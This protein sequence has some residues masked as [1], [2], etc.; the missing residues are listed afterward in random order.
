MH[1]VFQ[2]LLSVKW[3]LFAKWGSSLMLLL[4]L[5]YTLIWT[6]LGIFIPRDRKYY[7]PISSNWWRLVLELIGVILTGYFIFMVSNLC[8]CC[9]LVWR[10]LC[11]TH[12][13][14]ISDENIGTNV[15]NRS[16]ILK[17]LKVCQQVIK[18]EIISKNW[19]SL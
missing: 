19:Y 7:D 12:V 1:P 8:C 15:Q 5:F 2:R 3:K 14:T 16:V 10:T 4:N 6:F 9:F 13:P 11:S 17:I 18:I